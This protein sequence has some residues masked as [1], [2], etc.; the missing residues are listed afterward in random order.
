MRYEYNASNNTTLVEA[1]LAGDMNYG[2]IG[3]YQDKGPDLVIRLAGQVNLTAAN[4]ALTS[5][6]SAADQRAGAALTVTKTTLSSGAYELTYTNVQGR[7]YSSFDEIYS[8]SGM[9]AQVFNN[10]GAGASVTMSGS[11]LI[12][13]AGV[14]GET[15][16]TAGSETYAF[17]QGYGN[18]TINGFSTSGASADTLQ[19]AKSAFSYLNANMT[20][21]QDLAAIISHGASGTSGFTIKDSYGDTLTLAGLTS[22]TLAANSGAFRF[23]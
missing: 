8:K 4:F 17:S 23:V 6:Q 1:N 18:A 10:T 2:Q 20:P 9:V 15:V 5:A 13:N 21:A 19:L 16:R 3:A 22:T 7:T 12:F 11:S 14:S